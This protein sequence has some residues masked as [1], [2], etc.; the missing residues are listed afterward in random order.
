MLNKAISMI[1][2]EKIKQ[3]LLKGHQHEDIIKKFN[4]K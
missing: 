3:K 4:W 2:L 1:D